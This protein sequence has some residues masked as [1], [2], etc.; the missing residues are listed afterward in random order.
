MTKQPEPAPPSELLAQAPV[1][2]TVLDTQGR[3]LYY[4]PYAPTILDRQ[5]AYLG[6][7]VR[8]LHNAASNAKIDAILDAYASGERREFGW[9]LERG[10]KRFAVRVRPWIKDGQ[11]AGVLHAVVLL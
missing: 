9:V 10:G 6:R 11:W 5:P 2:L 4:N 8:E 1:A 7:D 3:L